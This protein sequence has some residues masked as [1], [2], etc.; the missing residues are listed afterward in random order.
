MGTLRNNA[1]RMELSASV[2]DHAHD[3]IFIADAEMNI[4]EVNPAFSKITGYVSR[5]L[6]CS[7]NRLGLHNDRK[8][9]KNTT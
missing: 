8:F 4:L 5:F 9:L 6:K 1:E 3:G 7:R 2:F